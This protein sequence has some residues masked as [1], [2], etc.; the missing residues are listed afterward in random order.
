MERCK[1]CGELFKKKKPEH[2][3]CKKCHAEWRRK[4][5]RE[6]EAQLQDAMREMYGSDEA[7]NIDPDIG[8]H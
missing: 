1:K 5:E 2:K 4:R 7:Y 6:A 3:F 8:H